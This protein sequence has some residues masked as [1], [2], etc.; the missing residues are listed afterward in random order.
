M[1]RGAASRQIGVNLFGHRAGDRRFNADAAEARELQAGMAQIEP[2]HQS[3]QVDL[4]ALGPAELD[5]GK[6]PKIKLDA[7][8]AVGWTRIKSAA[9]IAADSVRRQ[10]DPQFRHCA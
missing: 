1:S 9:E 8:A 7:G 10:C 6:A 2:G 5:A 3:K 4:D